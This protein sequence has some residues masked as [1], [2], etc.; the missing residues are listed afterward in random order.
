MVPPKAG[1][2]GSK[3]HRRQQADNKTGTSEVGLDQAEG[4]PAPQPHARVLG[5]RSGA[6]GGS[7]NEQQASTERWIF[8]VAQYLVLSRTRRHDAERRGARRK[9]DLVCLWRSESSTSKEIL[10]EGGKATNCASEEVNNHHAGEKLVRQGQEEV[11]GII[12]A[13]C[14]AHSWDYGVRYVREKSQR[15]P[16]HPPSSPGQ[17]IDMV[18]STSS[19]GSPR[20]TRS[21][22]S[23]APGVGI[24]LARARSRSPPLRRRAHHSGSGIWR[25]G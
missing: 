14:D 10:L 22:Y 1:I 4:N 15:C 8:F 9:G 2:E 19:L 25:W 5:V 13:S 12:P 17:I 6:S 24:L 3:K 21:T 18:W 11:D 7:R 20:T 23:T 16:V